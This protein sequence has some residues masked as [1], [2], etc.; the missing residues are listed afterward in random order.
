MIIIKSSHWQEGKK[1]DDYNTIIILILILMIILIILIV[2]I[3]LTYNQNIFRS[4]A[5]LQV[6]TLPTIPKLND[7][8]TLPSKASGTPYRYNA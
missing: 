3:L 6:I 4:M 7:S 2:M 8:Q 1:H 5:P